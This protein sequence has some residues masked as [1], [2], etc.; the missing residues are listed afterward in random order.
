MLKTI[1]KGHTL[2]RSPM[3]ARGRDVPGS[4][5]GLTSL[6]G[7]IENIQVR[8]CHEISGETY[9]CSPSGQKP[10]KCHLC[11]RQFSRSDHLS[12]HMKRH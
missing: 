6:Q 8:N 9:F 12:L 11:G 1:L 7:I 10:F 4:L 3:S 5:L 2:A